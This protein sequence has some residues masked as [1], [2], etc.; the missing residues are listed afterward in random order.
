MSFKYN[1]CPSSG[2]MDCLPFDFKMI[3]L[4]IK[5]NQIFQKVN[6]FK[7]LFLNFRICFIRFE[8]NC[9]RGDRQGDRGRGKPADSN[10]ARIGRFF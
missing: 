5:M 3:F 1:I 6:N 10:R 9:E 2:L 4:T 7:S 8:S